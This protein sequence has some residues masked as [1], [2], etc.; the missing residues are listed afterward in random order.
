ME[1]SHILDEAFAIILLEPYQPT[2]WHTELSLRDSSSEALSIKPLWKSCSDFPIHTSFTA[3][4]D[5]VVLSALIEICFVS[6]VATM[7]IRSVE[8]D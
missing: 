7:T 1:R 3:S 2:T 6:A 5:N 8:V 4:M